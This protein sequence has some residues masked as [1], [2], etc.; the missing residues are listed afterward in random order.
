MGQRYIAMKKIPY[1]VLKTLYNF[2]IVIF[3]PFI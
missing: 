1:D 2:F 3:F